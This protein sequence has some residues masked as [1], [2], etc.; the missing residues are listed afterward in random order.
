[1]KLTFL[2][3]AA[4]EGIPAVWCNCPTCTQAKQSGGKDVRTRSQ[5]LVGDDLLIDFP[6]DTYMHVLQNRLDLSRVQTVLITHAHM[7]HCYPGEFVLHGAPYA[8]NLT[9]PKVTVYGN[10]TVAARFTR[11]TAAELSET[12]APSVPFV[13]VH[14]FDSFQVPGGYCVTALPA[15]HT[16]GEECL[17]YAVRQGDKTILQCNDSGVLPEETF[18][19]MAKR[20]LRFDLAAFDCTYGLVKHGPGRHMGALDAENVRAQL[21]KHGLVH[22]HTKFVLTHFSHNGAQS[23]VEMERIE[24]PRGFIVA[25]DGLQIEV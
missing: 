4:A 18:A 15:V 8:H 1:M 13:T 2:G 23:H 22:E 14:P 6:M 21:K 17:I 3:T 12:I 19:Q 10:E 11:E 16:K 24:Q 5:I 7:D 25:Y 20:G 9:T